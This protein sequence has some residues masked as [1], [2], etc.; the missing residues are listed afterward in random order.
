MSF[1]FS[2]L[3]KQARSQCMYLAAPTR[4]L[5]RCASTEQGWG[6]ALNLFSP[7]LKCPCGLQGD[8]TYLCPLRKTV[9]LMPQSSSVPQL[10]TPSR[11]SQLMLCRLPCSSAFHP[12]APARGYMLT[13]SSQS[14]QHE[15]LLVLSVPPDQRLLSS[16]FP[17]FI[18]ELFYRQKNNYISA[19]ADPSPLGSGRG[20]PLI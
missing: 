3:H 9:K 11:T 12:H 16:L 1:R 14:Y 20:P 10:S 19:H 4:S 6:G 13:N 7:P 8:L 15:P 5:S 17:Q 2:E 18:A